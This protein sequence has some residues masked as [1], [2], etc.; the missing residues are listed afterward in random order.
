[1]EGTIT[2]WQ[3]LWIAIAAYVIGGVIGFKW[4]DSSGWR[5]AV[6]GITRMAQDGAVVFTQKA[7]DTLDGKRRPFDPDPGDEKPK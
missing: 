7:H 2:Y 5:R 6:D 3:M 4:G 1:M